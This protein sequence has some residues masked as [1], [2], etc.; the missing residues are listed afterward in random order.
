MIVDVCHQICIINQGYCLSAYWG[1]FMIKIL[2]LSASK[3]VNDWWTQSWLI[4]NQSGSFFHEWFH[5]LYPAVC[6]T[7]SGFQIL[8][9]IWLL[10]MCCI[11]LSLDHILENQPLILSPR[12]SWTSIAG[13]QMKLWECAL[14]IVSCLSWPLIHDIF[15]YLESLQCSL[16][17]FICCFLWQWL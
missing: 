13:N 5:L 1:R 12:V 10:V 17:I 4:I 7:H 3:N 2:E 11:Y 6:L 8:I 14:F 15:T 9:Y 16:C